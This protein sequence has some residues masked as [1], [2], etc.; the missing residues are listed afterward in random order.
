M[1]KRNS[2]PQRHLGT[3]VILLLLLTAAWPAAV[4]G[5]GRRP[6][7]EMLR[8]LQ[9][10]I[11]APDSFPRFS[12]MTEAPI[13]LPESDHLSWYGLTFASY[14]D[15]NWEIY[16]ANGDG[17]SQVN[18]TNKP[19]VDSSP[20]LNHDA[21]QIIFESW[22]DGNCEI[23]RMATDGTG[24]QRLTSTALNE[25][26]PA[27]SPDGS[28]IAYYGYVNTTNAEI[29]IVKADG[30]DQRRLTNDPAWDGH[31][32]WSPD[33][34][35]IAFASNRGG[36]YGIWMM[37]ADGSNLHC[38]RCDFVYAAY[39]SWSPDG[40]WIAL[41]DDANGDYWLDLAI[42]SA[43][44]ATVLHPLASESDYDY[45]APTWSPDGQDLAVA[46][47]HWVFQGG[48]WGWDNAYI[49]G[50]ALPAYSAYPLVS[51]GADWWPDWESRDPWPPAAQMAPLPTWVGPTFP[52]QWSGSDTGDS[53][54]A[55]YELEYRDGGGDW[56]H[57]LTPTNTLPVTFTEGYGDNTYGFRCRATDN[58]GNVGEYSGVVST[59]M[60]TA[61]P[62]STVYALL[63][64][65]PEPAFPI[66]WGGEDGTGSG[67][68]VYDV[69][70]RDG[71]GPTWIDWV[72]QIT[73]TS[74][75]FRGEVGH[76]YYF[77]SRAQ[78]NVGNLEDYPGGDGDAHTRTPPYALQGYVLD[79]RKQPV[80]FARITATPSLSTTTAMSKLGDGS[81]AMYFYTPGD[82]TLNAAHSRL[83]PAPPGM[84]GLELPAAFTP[85]FYL[86]PPEDKVANGGFES[87]NLVSWIPSGTITPILTTTAHTGGWAAV[88]GGQ[89]PSPVVTPTAAFTSSATVTTAGGVVIS[90]VAHLT[91]PTD[92][93]SGTA[94]FTLSGVPTVTGLPSGTQDIS[95]HLDWQ[96]TLTD[97]TP[98]TKTLRAVT[99]TVVYSDSQWRAAQVAREDTLALWRSDPTT[100]TWTPLNSV[101]DTVSNTV[102]AMVT[103]TGRYA[104]LG[105]LA[106]GPWESV[107]AQEIVLSPTLSEGTLSVLYNMS[108]TPGTNDT[109]TLY[110]QVAPTDTLTYTLP[111]TT[112]VWVHEWRP[113][114][115]GAGPT[116]TVR[117][118]WSQSH[119]DPQA[120]VLL[121]EVSLGLLPDWIYRIYL[122]L[123]GEK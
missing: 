28:Q 84:Q 34:T 30:S 116:V 27:W 76:T 20:N 110:L 3:I 31:P 91:Y 44:G 105:Q 19:G 29:Y 45:T 123:V 98:L 70:Y 89:V 23:Y 52:V 36:A 74:S 7:S 117:L 43:D 68:A 65:S 14:R 92:T 38:L 48:S 78:D 22:R 39:P 93:V 96:V 109:L 101:L 55:F 82:Y 122:P 58:A 17:T 10:R 16:G 25:Y 15:G 69:Q 94:V 71:A 18:L 112:G 81:F 54:I 46:K 8:F 61:A 11:D 40:D 120:Q 108:G 56:V 62:T 37:N 66:T 1:N 104:L 47:V 9:Q 49:Y 41:S 80:P 95:I 51:R 97:G 53:D 59:T 119:R 5:Q 113:V 85:T 90:P 57:W 24:L 75:I 73:A 79:T 21:T 86:P 87:G 103:Q 35:R 12:G 106:P 111:L 64:N 118:E 77:R 99:L 121:D 13:A 102:T 83:D 33:G 67:I 100:S 2:Y 63:P 88:L 60:D 42:M 6:D 50:Y 115:P 32:T 72:T 114:P 107:L 4:Q 26:K